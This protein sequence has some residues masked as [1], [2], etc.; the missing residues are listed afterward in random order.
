MRKKGLYVGKDTSYF[1]KTAWMPLPKKSRHNVQGETGGSVHT[2]VHANTTNCWHGHGWFTSH[3]EA[4]RWA[5]VS[6][7]AVGA[8]VDG[9]GKTTEARGKG[10]L[11]KKMTCVVFFFPSFM[12]FSAGYLQ[13][14]K[15]QLMYRMAIFHWG[16]MCHEFLRTFSCFVK[17]WVTSVEQVVSLVRRKG[18]LTHSTC[19]SIHLFN[20]QLPFWV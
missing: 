14:F 17:P 19:I 2:L 12:I 3:T 6:W 13:G 1:F 16:W 20:D 10:R 5:G 18:S 7:R 9:K 4:L 15:G 11:L 8:D